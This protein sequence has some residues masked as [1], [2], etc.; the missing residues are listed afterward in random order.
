MGQKVETRARLDGKLVAG[1][2]LLE[3]DYVLFRGSG[4]GKQAPRKK[5][6]FSEIQSLQA[7]EGWLRITHAGGS[8]ELELG[9][10][11]D[12]WAQ[13]IR[14]PKGRLEKLG[15]AAGTRLTLTGAVDPLFRRE[16][17]ARGCEAV[18]AAPARGTALVFYGAE[19]RRDLARVKTLAGRLAPT[20]AL[21]VIYPKGQ[22]HITENNVIAAGRAAGLKDVKVVGFSATHTAL[23][24]VIP[25]SSR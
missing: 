12:Q 8:L 24:F 21:W 13:K 19:A 3:T 23:K 7:G 4:A 20:G 6:A 16:L 1:V 2:A 18:E 5:L 22:K 17:A 14:S 10:R 9:E 25:L 11:A 15:A